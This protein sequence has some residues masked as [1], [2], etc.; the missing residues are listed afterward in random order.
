DEDLR[1][2]AADGKGTGV[3]TTVEFDHAHAR[4]FAAEVEPGLSAPEARS[5][6]QPREPDILEPGRL[7][8][9]AH[10]RPEPFLARLRQS[11]PGGNSCG[12]ERR[13]EVRAILPAGAERAV[14]A[15]ARVE[16]R[17]RDDECIDKR[18]LDA[19]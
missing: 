16:P 7:R 9:V 8:D 17:R 5:E 1:E 10:V 11:L 4:V 12:I 2:L 3:I 6:R 13:H 15:H 14:D 18:P 19:V